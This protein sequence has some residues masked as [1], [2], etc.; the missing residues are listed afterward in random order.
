[1]IFRAPYPDVTI[2]EVSI[3]DFIFAST[4]AFKD[5]TA[6]VDGPTGRSLTY[7]EFE[8]AVRRTAASLAARGFK[9]GD[10]FAIFSTNCVEYAIAF[11]A[12]AILGGINTTLNPLYT[13]E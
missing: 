6:L 11:H 8:D 12:V 7:A 3:T 1:M 10:V 2:P 5:K 4:A 13:A 9:K